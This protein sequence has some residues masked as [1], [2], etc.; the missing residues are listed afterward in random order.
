MTT[1]DL[2][3]ISI[4]VLRRLPIYHH[5]I[6]TLKE[7]GIDMVSSTDIAEHL[8]IDPIQVRK[9]LAITGAVGKP[10][11]GFVISDLIE[12]IENYLGWRRFNEAVLVG[13]GDLGSALVGYEGFN[14]YGFNIVT[15]FDVDEKKIG[16]K[17]HDKPVLHISKLP[18]LCQRLHINIGII[19]VPARNAQEV[20][21]IMIEGGIKAI[22]NFAPAALNLPKGIII[23]QENIVGSLAILMKQLS[24]NYPAI[25]RLEGD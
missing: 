17:I 4:P 14:D 10:K 21:D 19:T 11:L 3:K 23:Q 5:Y 7:S 20:A 6:I 8:N 25:N 1:D 12:H 24:T 9:D 22:W 18:D 16:Q 2:M 15:A 13:C